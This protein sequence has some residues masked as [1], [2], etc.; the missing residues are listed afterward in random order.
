MEA[1]CAVKGKKGVVVDRET[2]VM[3]NEEKKRRRINISGVVL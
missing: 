2:I 3:R 1:L